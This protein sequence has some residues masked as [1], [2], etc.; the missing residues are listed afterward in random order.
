MYELRVFAKIDNRQYKF[1][2]N[3]KIFD[4]ADYY[5]FDSA[6]HMADADRMANKRDDE[7]RVSVAL[8]QHHSL[9]NNSLD[10]GLFCPNVHPC[11]AVRR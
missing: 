4:F 6:R 10:Q 11:R 7:L 1:K 5:V 9:S 3:V 8:F 2:S